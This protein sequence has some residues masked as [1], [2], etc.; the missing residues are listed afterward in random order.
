MPTKRTNLV[1]PF[2]QVTFISLAILCALSRI[3]DYWHHW[4]DVLVGLFL[5]TIVA[6]FIVS[7]FICFFF[8]ISIYLNHH[9]NNNFKTEPANARIN[10]KPQD[11]GGLPPGNLTI[12]GEPKSNSPPPE[13]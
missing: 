5:G 12:L 3:F 8:M 9:S 4:S 6:F 1:K 11:G 10:V 2:A 7:F 13:N